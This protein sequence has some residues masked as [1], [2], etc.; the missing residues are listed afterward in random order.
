MNPTDAG[1]NNNFNY[2]HHSKNFG[3]SASKYIGK[4]SIKFGYD[5]RRLHADTVEKI[6]EEVATSRI[7]ERVAT[8][9]DD[10]ASEAAMEDRKRE[11]YF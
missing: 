4:H 6:I 2:V 11:G 9:A 8:R 10:R 7:T 3:A 5:F 1:T